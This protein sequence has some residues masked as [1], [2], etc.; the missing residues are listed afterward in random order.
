M[1]LPVLARPSVIA[2]QIRAK[3]EG[4]D[5]LMEPASATSVPLVALSQH[6]QFPVSQQYAEPDVHTGL[7]PMHSAACEE[8][9]DE[10]RI[11]PVGQ[12][13][14]HSAFSS[15]H[16]QLPFGQQSSMLLQEGLGM[17]LQAPSS[18]LLAE[19]EIGALE[20]RGALEEREEEDGYL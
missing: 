18:T 10:E 14:G 5:G 11:N 7:V 8:E 4:R 13:A 19:E 3:S 20:D 6:D 17:P 2:C 1:N 16:F 15:Q 9:L 12:S